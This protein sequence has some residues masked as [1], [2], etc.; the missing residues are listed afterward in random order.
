MSSPSFNV[1]EHSLLIRA[2][3]GA[4]KTTT[5]IRTFIEFCE[6]FER[7][8]KR[9]PRV[10]ITTFTRK[11]TQEVKE[12]LSVK[13]LER[14]DDRLFQHINKKS[15][16]HISTIHG[17]LTMMVQENAD[18]LGLPQTIRIIDQNI[19]KKNLK[20]MV[21]QALKKDLK[22][23]EI[24][25]HY[26]FVRVVDLV[27]QAI[28]A[29]RQAPQLQVVSLL[30]LRKITHA[31]LKL[32]R[33]QL[34][35]VIAHVDLAPPAWNE[36]F[37]Y[38]IRM[39]AL[40]EAEDVAAI[41]EHFENKPIKPRWNKKTP[42][43]PQEVHDHIEEFWDGF[44]LSIIDSE[45]YFIE[46]DKLGQLFLEFSKTLFNLDNSRKLLTGEITINDL[47][48]FSL[49]LVRSHSAVVA[50]F[51]DKFDYYMIDEFQ[52]TSPLQVEI[53][54]QLIYRKPH[55][56]VG[57]PQQSIYL[58]RGAR[59][60]V[61]LLKQEQAAAFTG[62]LQ[63]QFLDTNYRSQPSVM[64]FINDYFQ[65]MSSQF[66]PMKTNP[67]KDA[68][69]S[70]ISFIQ[71]ET[72][73]I[74]VLQHISQLILQGV[75][76][77]DI[78]VLSRRNQ[79]LLKIAA[80]AQKVH[81]P[82]QLQVSAGFDQRREI[83]D[84]IAILKFLVNPHDNENLV[85]LL[86][87]PWAY[88]SDVE[89]A[90]FA[91]LDRSLWYSLIQNGSTNPTVMSLAN[92]F[93]EYQVIGVSEAFMN[94]IKKMRFLDFSAS[95]DNSGKRE[96]NFW[97][98]YTHLKNAERNMGFSLGKYIN[99]NFQ[100]LQSD[101]GSSQSEALPVAQPDRVSLMTI[102]A[103]KGLEFPHVIV[104]GFS[105]QPLLTLYQPQSISL[106]E[107]KMSLAPYI[108]AESKN[109]VSRWGQQL[110]QEFNAME[111]QEHERLLYV[112]LTRAQHSL[113]LVAESKSRQVASSWQKKSFWPDAGT[114]EHEHYDLISV[115]S[116]T[117]IEK[118]TPVKKTVEAIRD[119]LQFKPQSHHSTSVTESLDHGGSGLSPAIQFDQKILDILKAKKGTDLHRLFESLQIFSGD[120]AMM[121]NL[122]QRLNPEQKK[123]VQY[124]L[125]VT[126]V[127]IRKIIE[128]GHVE[129]GFGLQTNRGVLQG[130]I[131]LWG[132]VAGEIYILDYKTGSSAYFE[133]AYQQLL[134]YAH[135]LY[136]MNLL[137]FAAPLN[138]VVTYPLEAKTLSRQFINFADLSK[139]TS[140]EILDLFG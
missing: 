71:A 49:E 121:E 131:D 3:A 112:A 93:S 46:H 27:L 127:P 21:R 15:S 17:L 33:S 122:N 79:N 109:A 41:L 30:D 104:V 111:S 31:K 130:Q 52:D 44:D 133:K 76:P 136:K 74:G 81:I 22:F 65:H 95:Y 12:R 39:D 105:E 8:N 73:A 90:S 118:L 50:D 96:A 68:T 23:L 35:Q 106:Q 140:P 10:A 135:C 36:Y 83:L 13:A 80:L 86:R 51:A 84:L 28:E 29:L 48:L 85:L 134:F 88:L 103:S 129:F 2:G 14:K 82:V 20:K 7:D 101:L 24:L 115:V 124:L 18:V 126:D 72:E 92:Y 1:T 94:F 91:K 57:D 11:A 54:D 108:V 132:V 4:G 40:L 119:K 97:K 98:F 55:F 75:S 5:L 61:F 32:W 99:D 16:V 110:R 25:E 26:S 100:F 47:E 123:S 60:E 114:H 117:E 70:K 42:P 77:K 6:K 53:L 139:K 138:F 38:L 9:L 59:S 125:S 56:I 63:L 64:N 87:S 107:N 78:C 116:D 67:F 113:A 66:A 89:I 128:F 19:Y 43:F 62:N 137:D 102:H 58:F 34:D 69:K 37:S 45:E 120:P